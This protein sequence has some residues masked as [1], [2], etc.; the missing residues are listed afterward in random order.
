MK[1]CWKSLPPFRHIG[2]S[3]MKKYY[4][5]RPV[6]SSTLVV[7][8]RAAAEKK[9]KKPH[10]VLKKGKIPT[11]KPAKKSDLVFLQ[12]SPNY[13]EKDLS[14]G[15]LGTVGRNCNRTSKGRFRVSDSD[16]DTFRNRN[17]VVEK[18]AN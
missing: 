13:C 15:S 2:D 14:A 12:M 7:G 4:R 5:A 6:A 8:P 10:L 17:C 3:L 1:T 16:S 18:C 9:S 11:K